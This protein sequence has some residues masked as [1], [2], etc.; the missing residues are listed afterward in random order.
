MPRKRTTRKDDPNKPAPEGTPPTPPAPDVLLDAHTAGRKEA[1]AEVFERIGG[2][3]KQG[4]HVPYPK[5]TMEWLQL[6]AF[7]IKPK[8]VGP[9][10]EAIAKVEG[11]DA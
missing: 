11:A 3:W 10:G 6:E 5:E 1:L 8:K 9:G 7:G 4:G 2:L